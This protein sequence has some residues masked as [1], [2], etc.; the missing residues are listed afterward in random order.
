MNI[1]EFRWYCDNFLSVIVGKTVY[2]QKKF[3]ELTSDI[4]TR[5]DEAFLLVAMEN[6]IDHWTAVVEDPKHEKGAY[7]EAKYTSKTDKKRH[8]GWNEEGIASYNR[9]MTKDI[10]RKRLSSKAL[11]VELRELY[12]NGTTK[13]SGQCENKVMA[14]LQSDTEDEQEVQVEDDED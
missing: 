9:Y 8:L 2:N 3:S 14:L 12:R 1:K 13:K 4:A 10:P 6:S 7:P 11:E 5:S